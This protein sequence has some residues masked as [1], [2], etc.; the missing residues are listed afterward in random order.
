MIP[1]NTDNIWGQA[2]AAWPLE[3]AQSCCWSPWPH[4]H[5]S[6][7]NLVCLRPLFSVRYQWVHEPSLLRRRQSKSAHIPA[8]T[9][10][11]QAHLVP[12]S[13]PE[14]MKKVAAWYLLHEKDPRFLREVFLSIFV[15]VVIG[16][17]HNKSKLL[18]PSWCGNSE[19]KAGAVW[20]FSKYRCTKSLWFQTLQISAFIA[21]SISL[22]SVQACLS[23]KPDW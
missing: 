9:Q 7:K 19:D 20:V 15:I 5:A 23:P 18:N 2:V 11:F 6:H 8:E 3:L 16:F 10:C 13:Q 22:F 17:V 14:H 21:Y 12:Q 4:I 1:I